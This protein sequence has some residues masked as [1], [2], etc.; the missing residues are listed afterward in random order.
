MTE[1]PHK[2]I[3]TPWETT[4]KEVERRRRG[5]RRRKQVGGESRDRILA[6]A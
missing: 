4:T 5:I 6:R 3:Q 2:L 1:H